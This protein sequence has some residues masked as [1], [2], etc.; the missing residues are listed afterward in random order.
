M[1]QTAQNLASYG[2]N[3][4]STLVHMSPQEVSGLQA[5][6][7]NNG[8]TLTINPSTGL[9]EAFSLGR[10][11]PMIAGFALGPAGL[12]MSAMQ[13]GLAAGA[14][15]TLATGSLREG[16]GIGLGAAGGAGLAGSMSNL[17]APASAGLPANAVAGS[18]G[19]MG[20]A[21][22]GLTIP[23]NAINAAG[24]GQLVN[25]AYMPK[26]G[27]NANAMAL[28]PLETAAG[29]MNYGFTAA[30][31]NA[32]SAASSL[33]S[34]G[35]TAVPPPGSLANNLT[36]LD[37]LK[38]S[39]LTPMPPQP[40]SGPMTLDPAQFGR[41]FD[42]NIT[43]V[44][45]GG[46]TEAMPNAYTIGDP[47][48]STNYSLSQGMLNAPR[49]PVLGGSAMQSMP[50]P[51]GG[52]SSIS[53]PMDAA[54]AGALRMDA[55]RSQAVTPSVTDAAG[56]YS[57]TLSPPKEIVSLKGPTMTDRFNRVVAGGE[58]AF[59]SM[60][61]AGEF[62][63]SNKMNLAMASAPM[64][65]TEPEPLPEEESYIRPYS[66]D[67][68]N[69]SDRPASPSGREEERL[70][71]KY[72]AGTPYRA[73]QGG[74]IAF[75]QGGN[76]PDGQEMNTNPAMMRRMDEMQI[77]PFAGIMDPNRM[78]EIYGMGSS[79]GQGYAE[80]G[81]T[82]RRE[83]RKKIN[84]MDDPYAFAAYQ[85]GRGLYDAALQNFAAG[86]LSNVPR[87]LSGG[88]DGMSDSIPA[89]IND[90]Q[91]ARLADGEFVI[92]AD[93]VSHLGNGSS[94]AGAKQL[95]AMMD[96]IRAKRTGKKKQAPAVNPRKTMPA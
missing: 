38:Q 15:G 74:I 73:A 5:L 78:K 51:A 49:P 57:G 31:P 50:S 42:A 9:P 2:R 13:A 16:I 58:K 18:P 19:I 53:G 55:L 23:T 68:E 54:E 59:G 43:K 4:D 20:G 79:G 6:A 75:A 94:K 46:T 52:V 89:S 70:R 96:R 14:L 81:E 40:L 83:V 60:D 34:P 12:G 37:A 76:M 86:G 1:N 39:A 32:A 80:G 28:P 64:F 62:L 56:G 36:G 87:F 63:G 77:P 11:L 10:L 8:T 65:L 47:S 24:P 69:L 3:G 29:G 7:R 72:T 95:Y 41:P 84:R 67:V 22:S 66:L 92:P 44:F 45:P 82:G 90:R 91:P 21:G 48:L 33:V 17:A 26:V 85:S 25:P 88:G 30:A 93:V 61:A 35:M 27:L 71:Y